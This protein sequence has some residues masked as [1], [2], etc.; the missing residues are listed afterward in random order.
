[1]V[2]ALSPCLTVCMYVDASVHPENS[3][4]MHALDESSKCKRV[5][6]SKYCH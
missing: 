5:E 4:K 6:N 3:F 2:S 1:M